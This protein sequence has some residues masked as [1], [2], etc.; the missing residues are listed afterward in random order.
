MSLQAE[1]I[2]TLCDTLGLSG[3]MADYEALAQSAAE[4]ETSYSD[5][6]EQSLRSEQLARQQ[7]TRSVLLNMAGFPSVK[8]WKTMISSSLL[9]HPKSKLKRWHRSALSSAR[10]MLYYSAPVGWVKPMSPL[11]WAFWPRKRA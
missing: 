4:A 7:R 10:R 3:L 5:Y 6:P 1:C 8:H 11:L 2:E 9:A